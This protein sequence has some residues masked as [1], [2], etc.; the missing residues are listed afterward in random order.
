MMDLSFTLESFEGP[1]DLLLHL[2]EKNKMDIYDI[3]ISTIT[4][5]YMAYLSRMGKDADTMSEFLI[6]ASTL[7]DIKARMLL[8][9]QQDE[10][11]QEEDPRA[12]LVQQL[13]EYKL[14]KY[15]SYELKDKEVN[16]SKYMYRDSRIPREVQEYTIPIDLDTY[17]EGVDLSR[18]KAVFDDVMRRSREKRNDEAIRYGKIKREMISMP[19]KLTYIRN[20][21]RKHKQFS[22]RKLIEEQMTRENIIVTFLAVLELIKSGQLIAVQEGE[23]DILMYS[24]EE[25]PASVQ[26]QPAAENDNTQ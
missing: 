6:M 5:Q 9:R 13:L 2:I 18:L 26:P 24:P 10:D 15:M 7:L 20:Y 1:L 14:Y 11:G 19:E 17:L 22:F 16:A 3:R 4:D 25:A 8:P 12:E 21:T 23:N